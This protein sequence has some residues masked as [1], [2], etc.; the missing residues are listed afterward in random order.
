[1]TSPL[2]NLA[3]RDGPIV[4][5]A[6]DDAEFAGLVRSARN[7]L[8]DAQ[9]TTLA[10]ESRFDLA[11]SAAFGFCLAA[12]RRRGY[13]AR[14]RRHF[15]TRSAWAPKSG[16][17]SRKRTKH[18]TWPNTRATRIS[19]NDSSRTP[20]PHVSRSPPR[21]T[22]SP[23][24]PGLSIPPRRAAAP[25]FARGGCGGVGPAASDPPVARG[26]PHPRVAQ[27]AGAAGAAESVHGSL[28][29]EPIRGYR[30]TRAPGPGS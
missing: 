17:C 18:A 13:R 15:R 22:R 11:Y 10:P 29:V 20:S 26:S 2:D 8:A 14:H 9:V 16:G 4:A 28:R 21:S 5:E 12:L 30:R 7:R 24:R 23:R 27:A 1:M 3:S 6:K 25:D 19:T